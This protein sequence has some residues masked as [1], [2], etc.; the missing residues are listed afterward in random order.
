MYEVII[1]PILPSAIILYSFL[2]LNVTKFI[3][4]VSTD[5]FTTPKTKARVLYLKTINQDEF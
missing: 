5:V 1:V 2:G 4:E 3:G